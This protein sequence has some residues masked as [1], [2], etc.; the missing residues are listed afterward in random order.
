MSLILLLIRLPFRCLGWRKC[1]LESIRLVELILMTAIGNRGRFK[2]IL[3]GLVAKQFE[4]LGSKLELYEGY[5]VI[6]ESASEV[7]GM[8]A[9]QCRITV[10]RLL[11]LVY[12]TAIGNENHLVSVIKT[13]NNLKLW[14]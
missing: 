1:N 9:M 3:C 4:A 5:V 6:D 10:S 11:E 8:E 7:P 13:H 12:R 2:K 14:Y